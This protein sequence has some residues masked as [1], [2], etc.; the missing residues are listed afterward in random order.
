MEAGLWVVRFVNQKSMK[1]AYTK[2]N[3]MSMK[4]KLR[5]FL[6]YPPLN[7]LSRQMHGEECSVISIQSCM[8]HLSSMNPKLSLSSTSPIS[9]T[10]F[11]WECLN[12]AF[13]KLP[14]A[15]SQKR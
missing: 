1:L 15:R 7:H 5:D 2:H 8:E 14:K 4:V 11:D 9:T 10:M 3:T 6:V 12:I 13:E